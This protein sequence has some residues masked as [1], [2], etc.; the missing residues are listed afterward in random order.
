ME[1]PIP[2][3][4]NFLFVQF[5]NGDLVCLYYL[6]VFSDDNDLVKNRLLTLNFNSDCARVNQL[7]LKN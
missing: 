3:D 4:L 2:G 1:Q 7:S 6:K 5:H